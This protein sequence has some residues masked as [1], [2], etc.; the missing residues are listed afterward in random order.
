M[1][2]LLAVQKQKLVHEGVLLDSSLGQLTVIQPTAGQNVHKK[3]YKAASRQW[4]N[5]SMTDYAKLPA[6]L[7]PATVQDHLHDYVIPIESL[8]PVNAGIISAMNSK[9]KSSS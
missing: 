9:T 7:S 3:Q 8:K 1:Q 6:N 5:S 4:Q 2:K